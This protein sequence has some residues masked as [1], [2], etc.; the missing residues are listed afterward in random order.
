MTGHGRPSS[1][2][3]SQLLAATAWIYV[4]LRTV[5][6]VA[7]P[8]AAPA[9]YLR[10]A[11]LT[12]VCFVDPDR[13]WAVGD[14]GAIW[15]T[16]DGGRH[17]RPQSSPATCRL[18][19]VNFVD[20][21]NGWIGGGWTHP[22]T[23]FSTGVVLRTFDGGQHWE[24]VPRLS[25][26][27]LKRLRFQDLRHG[28][29]VGQA[30]SMYPAGV[31]RTD[32]G[33]R[34]WS[35]V[36]G[37]AAAHWLSGDFVDGRTGGVAGRDGATAAVRESGLEPADCLELGGRHVR[38]LRLVPAA[39]AQGDAVP[40]PRIPRVQ[41]GWLVGDGGL[42]LRTV[43]GGRS[44]QESP[45][46]LPAG[47]YD[48]FDYR[49]VAVWGDCCW[50]A[51]APG[52]RVLRT[53]DG[54]LQWEVFETGQTVPIRGLTFLDANRGWAVGALG[55]ILATRDGGRTWTTQL[56]GGTRAAL[57]GIFSEAE[58]IPLEL[59]AGLGGNDGYLTVVQVLHRREADAAEERTPLE[60]RTHAAVVA[61]GGS[62]AETAWHFP[63][64]P[65]G[66]TLPADALVAAWDRLHEGRGQERLEEHLV[67]QIRQWRPEVIVT[68]P[69]SPRGDQPLLHLD[70]QLVL[71]AVTRAADAASFPE[72]I[73]VGG[74]QPWTVK[75]VLGSSGADTPGVVNIT[76]SHLTPRLGRSLAEQAN[77]GWPLLRE[78]PQASPQTLGF[79]LLVNRLP[80]EL[81]RKDF[82][83]GIT[84]PTAGDARRSLATAAPSDV[85]AV[86]LAAQQRRNVSK[87]LEQLA[88][89]AP[90]G[91]AWLGQVED[92]TRGLDQTAS[93]EV[94]FEMA[95]TMARAGQP[96]L[97]AEVYDLLVKKYPQQPL[98]EAALIWL[99]QYYAS[100][101]AVLFAQIAA[102][103]A[104]ELAR[105][106]PA[107]ALRKPQYDVQ[108]ATFEAPL[109]QPRT[110]TAEARVPRVSVTLGLTP[111]DRARRAMA[112]ADV[113]QN[114][115]PALSVEPAIRFPL[116]AALRTAEQ[117]VDAERLYH[118]MLGSRVHDAWWEC[119]RNEL[120]L[121][122][123]VRRSPRPLAQCVQAEHKPKLDGRLD[124]PVWQGGLPVTL[125]SER[126]D[127]TDWPAAVMFAYDAEFLYLAVN[128]RRASAA[129]YNSSTTARPRDPD[130]SEHDRVDVLLDP[131]RDYATYYRLTVDH[132]GWVQEACLENTAWNPQWYIA[133]HDDGQAWSVEAAIP[134]K[135][136]AGHAPAKQQ[137]WAV[138]IQ[139]TIPGVG[140]QSWSTPAA[141]RIRPEGFGLLTFD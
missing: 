4:L 110:A 139:R 56:R 20:D 126:R 86:T 49:A 25:L 109:G 134:W 78:H 41:P 14:R 46:R 103:P 113:V 15:H 39:Q 133:A 7:Q 69:A 67:R 34:S 64:P 72:Q 43:D 44:W 13:G 58:R 96:Q 95:E 112:Y 40:D 23:F 24:Q 101:E 105:T 89:A 98:C 115:W 122:R 102:Q 30:S 52:T 123:P 45:G 128:C 6:S 136:L 55:T 94:L 28:W 29:A 8:V 100:G 17:W 83:S 33:G 97:A 117:P 3:C 84:L 108:P 140:F 118:A 116:A 38:S 111:K 129:A 32:D 16:E 9:E 88:T 137:A 114:A 65:A 71:R 35:S 62:Q 79:A 54:G 81:G 47:M 53:V 11:E 42:V 51:G 22:Y 19:V 59:L 74:L 68:E 135:E 63:V 138:G 92:L 107:S 104:R 127:D 124:D 37:G 132:R 12:D 66:L 130:L 70:N 106:A 1:A 82:F 48:Q 36:P 77:R 10:D 125:T 93:A 50:I 2:R 31:F 60:E 73:A 91:A 57:L 120:W 26:P 27:A 18:E 141:I 99:V 61:V 21:R 76:L 121:L 87:L 75:K 80:Q 5:V 119:A 90:N 131:D 85:R